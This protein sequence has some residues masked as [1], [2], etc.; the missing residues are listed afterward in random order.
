MLSPQA[1]SLGVTEDLAGVFLALLRHLLGLH[2]DDNSRHVVLFASQEGFP[3]NLKV[4]QV[5]WVE[6]AGVNEDS[7]LLP[8]HQLSVG[9][10]GRIETLI[11]RRRYFAV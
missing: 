11:S 6:G 10:G 2:E 9:A 8:L 7:I 3:E 5:W 4:S 1:A